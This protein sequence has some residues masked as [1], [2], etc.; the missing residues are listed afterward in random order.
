[1]QMLFT[2]F[3][4]RGSAVASH[5]GLDLRARGEADGVG[6]G[7]EGALAGIPDLIL[8]V[9][10]PDLIDGTRRPLSQA[11]V[12]VPLAQTPILRRGAEAL[13]EGGAVFGSVL[14][15]RGSCLEH[16]TG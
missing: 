10:G 9:V 6:H 11:R 15:F 8:D 1:M 14:G 5:I 12:R 16:A 3:N 7:R 13:Q 2:I 4:G